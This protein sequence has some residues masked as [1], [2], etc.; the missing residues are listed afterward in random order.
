MHLWLVELFFP[1]AQLIVVVVDPL[2]Q[3]V[4]GIVRS[5]DVFSAFVGLV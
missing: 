5:L 4:H 3:H 1:R 2:H